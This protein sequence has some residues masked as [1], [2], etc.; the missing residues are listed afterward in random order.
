MIEKFLNNT[1]IKKQDNIL[2][3]V[4]YIGQPLSLQRGGDI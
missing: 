2:Q 1:K 4:D 3:R